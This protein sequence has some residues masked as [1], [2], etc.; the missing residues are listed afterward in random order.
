MDIYGHC[1]PVWHD[2][3]VCLTVVAVEY[4]LFDCHSLGIGSF[5]LKILV[6]FIVCIWLLVFL[7]LSNQL[8]MSIKT[9]VIGAWVKCML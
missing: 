6:K 9:K 2:I 4:R 3:V 8:E 7:M 5:E 1:L